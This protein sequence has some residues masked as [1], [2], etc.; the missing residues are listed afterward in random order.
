MAI[1][2]INFF[3]GPG[4]GKSTVAPAVFSFLKTEHLNVELVQ[5]FIKKWAYNGNTPKSYD[6]LYI[7]SNQLHEEDIFL[8]HVDLIVTDSPLYMQL[9][10]IQKYNGN[11]FDECL[12]ICRKFEENFPSLNITLSRGSIKYSQ[13]GRYE[14]Y[15]EAVVMD[16]NIKK[17]LDD[18]NLK[19][20][21]FETID[22]KNLKHTVLDAINEQKQR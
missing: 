1:R 16:Y 15:D 4:C 12:S 21:D 18:L 17:L 7:F 2:R 6:Q 22:L 8:R 13:L 3:G 9:A 11:C 14:S 19:Y 10:Y 5:E 20:L